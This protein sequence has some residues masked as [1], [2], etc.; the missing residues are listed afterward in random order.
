VTPDRLELINFR[1]HSKLVLDFSK[2]DVAAILGKNGVG[3]S[4]IILA[5]LYAIWG[6]VPK[7]TLMELVN[8]KPKVPEMRVIY[9]FWHDDNCKYRIDRG[10]RITGSKKRATTSELT[11]YKYNPQTKKWADVM[12]GNSISA[13]TATIQ[14]MIGGLS[15]EAAMHSSLAMQDEFSKFM[16]AEASERR[17]IFEAISNMAIYDRLNKKAK[18]RA[19]TAAVIIKARSGDDDDMTQL[20]N[21]LVSIEDSIELLRQDTTDKQTLQQVLMGQIATLQATIG[22]GLN[23]EKGR[24]SKLNTQLVTAQERLVKL[25]QQQKEAELLIVNKAEIEAAYQ[26]ELDLRQE[27]QTLGEVERKLAS[28]HQRLAVLLAEISNNQK[29]C[30]ELEAEQQE[31]VQRQDAIKRELRIKFELSE[32]GLIQDALKERIQGLESEIQELEKERRSIVMQQDITDKDYN[33]YV[34]SAAKA[35]AQQAQLK[36]RIKQL[37]EAK[38]CPVLFRPCEH[39]SGENLTGEVAKLLNKIQVFAKQQE[40]VDKAVKSAIQT[41]ASLLVELN[42]VDELKNDK[43]KMI[44]GI[45][46]DLRNAQTKLSELIGRKKVV[47][48]E[49]ESR[50]A[51]LL[52]LQTE[53]KELNANIGNLSYDETRHREVRK[54]L[55]ELALQKLTETYQKLIL[56]EQAIDSLAE[57]AELLITTID[58]TQ[59]EITELTKLIAEKQEK[60]NAA[61]PALEAAQRELAKIDSELVQGTR[62][63]AEFIEQKTRLKTRQEQAE[64]NKLLLAEQMEIYQKYSS[65]AKAYQITKAFIVENAV[66]RYQESCNQMLE[67]LG[68]N[69]RVRIETLREAKD[70]KPNDPKFNKVF[71]IVVI[72]AEGK[73]RAYHTWSGGEKHRVNLALRHA[74]SMMLLNRSGAKLGLVAIDE[75]DTRLD[76]EGKEALLKMIDATNTGQFG[77]PAKVLFIT[78]SED[79]K[80]RL[81]T[82]ILLEK[83]RSGTKV[84]VS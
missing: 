6:K 26:E 45:E 43:E 37:E 55:A 56:A 75:G 79:L 52:S 51:S 71:E 38:E 14:S 4:S 61:E 8:D 74:L 13:T 62:R 40:M 57:Q 78:H 23:N 59:D 63:L 33:N 35:E 22:D 65:L 46:S 36:E 24:L 9:D 20:E 11:L 12:S 82:R 34:A 58:S 69:I 72:D 39:I 76:P 10:V 48:T 5:L 53:E 83:S 27:N 84:I 28:T 42:R 73:E 80:D 30:T 66:P 50:T 18:K 1:S 41:K 70:S 17:E 77:F 81:P 68:L 3:K 54:M 25:Q 7:Y 19:E 2:I 49:I 32:E 67:Y 16:D 64:K 29:R 47:L 60:L 31:L 15:Q 44:V 21:D